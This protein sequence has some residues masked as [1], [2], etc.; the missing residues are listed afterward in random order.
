LPTRGSI[1]GTNFATLERFH[2]KKLGKGVKMIP[3]LLPP[4]ILLM[5][6]LYQRKFSA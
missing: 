5:Q 6:Q 3:P 1:I 2:Y 4:T